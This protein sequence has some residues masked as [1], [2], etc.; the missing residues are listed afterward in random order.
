MPRNITWC[1]KTRSKKQHST[2]SVRMPGQKSMPDTW[3]QV[4]KCCLISGHF[5]INILSLRRWWVQCQQIWATNLQCQIWACFR[6]QRRANLCASWMQG[7][8]PLY[9]SN[10]AGNRAFLCHFSTKEPHSSRSFSPLVRETRELRHCR[11]TCNVNMLIVNFFGCVGSRLFFC[12]EE[13]AA[14]M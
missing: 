3:S 2:R 8:V 10:A 12:G 1:R 6:A 4:Y 14:R 5:K 13:R 9:S 11:L 7:L